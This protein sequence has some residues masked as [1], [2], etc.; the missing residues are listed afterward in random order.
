MESTPTHKYHGEQNDRYDGPMQWPGANGFPFLGDIAPS[1]KQSEVE[2]LPIVGRTHEHVFDLNSETEREYYNWVRD[3]IRNGL[4]IRD[5]ES[6]QWPDPKGWPII[7][8]EWTQCFVM[9]P[10][11][12]RTVGSKEHGSSTK[13]TLRRPGSD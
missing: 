13:F 10:K 4:F 7:Y 11:A 12:Q 8:L 1:L 6:R 2:S 9:A 3:R 5:F